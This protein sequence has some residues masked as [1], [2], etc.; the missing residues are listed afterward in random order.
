ML[1]YLFLTLLSMMIGIGHAEEYK[2]SLPVDHI[3]AIGNSVEKSVR[4]ASV[5][6]SVPFTGGHGSGSYVKYKDVHLVI[7]AQHVTDG[8]LGSTYVVAHRG[9]SHIAVLIYSDAQNDIA[10]L[11]V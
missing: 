1:K 8:P 11:Y 6:V 3:D 7:T 4:Q 9:E 2:P 10:V 5:R